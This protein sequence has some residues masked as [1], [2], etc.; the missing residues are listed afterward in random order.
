MQERIPLEARRLPEAFHRIKIWTLRGG[1][2]RHT[3]GA[4]G[5]D[6]YPNELRAAQVHHRLEHASDADGERTVQFRMIERACGGERS[7]GHPPQPLVR[8]ANGGNAL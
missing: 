8:I 2:H 3:I 7:I 1:R 6:S 5:D 4:V